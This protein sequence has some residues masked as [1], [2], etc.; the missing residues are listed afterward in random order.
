MNMMC[1]MKNMM[2]S[3][4]L[5]VLFIRF[6]KA[7]WNKVDLTVEVKSIEYDAQRVFVVLTTDIFHDLFD[8]G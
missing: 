7:V 5:R 1:L 8:R 6:E 3:V 4:G 2:C